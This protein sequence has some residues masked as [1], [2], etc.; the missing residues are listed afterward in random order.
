MFAGGQI[1][2]GYQ[3]VEPTPGWGGQSFNALCD[4]TKK[5]KNGTAHT[6]SE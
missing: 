2:G 6:L 3:R 1:Q 4:I 5:K